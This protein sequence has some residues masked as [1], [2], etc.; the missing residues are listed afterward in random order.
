MSAAERMRRYRARL[1][2][3]G[4]RIRSVMHKDSLLG[5]VGFRPDTLLTPGEQHVLQRFCSRFRRLPRL[6]AR[7]GVFG[8]R[9]KGGASEHS[10]L[11]VA[12]LFCG[13]RDPAIERILYDIASEAGNPYRSGQYGIFLKP[14]P[15][16]EDQPD[17]F[18]N[19]IR[20]ELEMV[21]TRPN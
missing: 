19:S 1:R 6:P 18:L 15:F 4:I 14:V 20:D 17:H 8:S 11:D 16:F 21:W 13:P 10:D 5:A 3:R 12:V 2:A 7:M 9:A